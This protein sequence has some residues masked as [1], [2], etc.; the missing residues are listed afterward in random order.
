MDNFK[1]VHNYKHIDKYRLSFN[2]LAQRTFNIDFEKWY[3]LGLWNHRYICY[4]YAEGDN[5]VSNISVN[6][7]ELIINGQRKS[8][9]QIGTV[10]TDPNYRGRGLATSLMNIVLK[11]YED[12]C[13]LVYLFPNVEVLDFYL[14]FGFT[15][16]QES[17]LSREINISKGNRSNIRKLDVSI[18]EDLSILTKLASKRI[19]NSNSFGADKADHILT[20]YAVNVFPH[21]IYYLEDK[22]IIVIF[23]TEDEILN[24]YDVISK[25]EVDLDEIVNQLSDSEIKKVIFHFTPHS[26]YIDEQ[27]KIEDLDDLIFVKGNIDDIPDYFRNSITAHA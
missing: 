3:Q 22:E 24:L 6:I 10:M 4:S 20:W 23:D 5:I 14:K 13:E 17:I 1:F 25:S 12:K 2:D 15:S 19:P 27:E 16:L 9:V 18:E 21:N 8:A 7:M 26:K 11:E